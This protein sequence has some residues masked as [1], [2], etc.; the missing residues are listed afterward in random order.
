MNYFIAVSSY[1]GVNTWASALAS[2]SLEDAGITHNSVLPMETLKNLAQHIC[3]M[4]GISALKTREPSFRTGL[5]CK[6]PTS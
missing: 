1:D 4:L 3:T 5:A 2:A 6:K